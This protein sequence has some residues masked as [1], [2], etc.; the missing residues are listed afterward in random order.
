MQINN[1]ISVYPRPFK[2]AINIKNP[3]L[4]VKLILINTLTAINVSD[5][6][7]GNVNKRQLIY[8]Q[9]NPSNGEHVQHFVTLAQVPISTKDSGN[10]TL[11]NISSLRTN[12]TAF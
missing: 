7:E 4:I 5:L 3:Q 11:S 2:I 10:D 12:E 1:L 9:T 8:A 6:T